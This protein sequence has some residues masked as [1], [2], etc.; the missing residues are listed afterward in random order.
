V[1]RIREVVADPAPTAGF[2]VILTPVDLRRYVRKMVETDLFRLPVLSFNEIIP[3]LSVQPLT[4]ISL[5]L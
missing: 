2:P 1:D 5:Q 4:R 3:E